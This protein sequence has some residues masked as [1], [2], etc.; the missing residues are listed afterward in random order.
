MQI[1]KDE[2]RRSNQKIKEQVEEIE[3]YRIM[4][5]STSIEN[6]LMKDDIE[7]SRCKH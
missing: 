7:I 3:M 5:D 4:L 2:I 6:I 1:D